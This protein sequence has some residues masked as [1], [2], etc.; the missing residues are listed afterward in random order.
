MNIRKTLLSGILASSLALSGAA[1]LAQDSTPDTLDSATPS[2]SPVADPTKLEQLPVID[3]EGTIVA[4]ADVWEDEDGNGVWF[5][6]TNTGDT[7]LAE[8]KYGVHVHEFGVCDPETDPPFD[9]AGGHFNPEMQDHGDINADPSHA[10]DLGN[11]E[12]DADGNFEHEVLAEG[13]TMQSGEMNSLNDAD[14]SALVIHAGEDDLATDPSGESGDRWA[15]AI[16]FASPDEQGTPE[17]SPMSSPVAS[18]AS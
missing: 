2:A 8:G 14:G 17:A 18:P 6:I 4:H 3:T 11:L 15:C 12:V 9:S 13:L 16:I 1:V 7:M 10:G 5:S